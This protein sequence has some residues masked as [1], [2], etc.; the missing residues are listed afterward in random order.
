MHKFY[1]TNR[2]ASVWWSRPVCWSEKCPSTGKTPP[3]P[4][5]CWWGH[6]GRR[7]RSS[8][9]GGNPWK[10]CCHGDPGRR[11]V[12]AGISEIRWRPASLTPSGGWIFFCWKKI[13]T[14]KNWHS[15]MLVLLVFAEFDKTT[16]KKFKVYIFCFWYLYV[17]W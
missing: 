2:S 1:K 11:R 8:C 4:F 13:L 16:L 7:R 6:V 17:F 9:C 3:G 14:S 15:K 5:S 12:F 10:G